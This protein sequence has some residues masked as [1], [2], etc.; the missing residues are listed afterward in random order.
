MSMRLLWRTGERDY[1][2]MRIFD[3]N[4]K[5]AETDAKKKLRDMFGDVFD[6]EFR[7]LDLKPDLNIARHFVLAKLAKMNNNEVLD[8]YLAPILM[9][10]HQTVDMSGYSSID[11]EAGPS[12]G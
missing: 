2:K 10:S 12:T 7:D 9:A 6:L 3:K 8:K 5:P 4:D 11:A 1:I